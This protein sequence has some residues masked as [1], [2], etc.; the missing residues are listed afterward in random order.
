VATP[1]RQKVVALTVAR[2]VVTPDEVPARV[3]TWQP[4][5]LRRLLDRALRV[6][7]PDH[8]WQP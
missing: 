6:V 8:R 4:D 1:A 7:A 5:S 2:V 3:S